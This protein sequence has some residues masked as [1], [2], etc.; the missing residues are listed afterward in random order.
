MI[1]KHWR[2]L[3][4]EARALVRSEYPDWSDEELEAVRWDLAKCGALVMLSTYLATT[5]RLPFDH[6]GEHKGWDSCGGDS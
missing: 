4:P 6:E 1:A 3:S 5:C 2:N